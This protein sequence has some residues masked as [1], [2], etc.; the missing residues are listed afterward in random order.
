MPPTAAQLWI[1]PSCRRPSTVTTHSIPPVG[2]FFRADIRGPRPSTQT[3]ARDPSPTDGSLPEVP[4]PTLDAWM[5]SSAGPF[6]TMNAGGPLEGI[7]T[8]AVATAGADQLLVEAAW[9]CNG[10]PRASSATV[11]GYDA[12]RALAHRWADQLAAG[13]E[14][15][16][17]PAR[18][19]AD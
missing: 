12:A 15:R 14:P 3:S 5:T 13:R 19:A 17:L 4:D 18:D 10:D 11:T 2:I 1:L 7:V 6:L 16:E 9:K 8:I